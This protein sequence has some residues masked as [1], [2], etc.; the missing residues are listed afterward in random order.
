VDEPEQD[1]QVAGET[2]RRVRTAQ[3]I[4]QKQEEDAKQIK[5]AT[6]SSLSRRLAQSRQTKAEPAKQA[7]A[8]K[9]KLETPLQPASAKSNLSVAA[10]ASAQSPATNFRR[11]LAERAVGALPKASAPPLKPSA[12]VAQ[13]SGLRAQPKLSLALAVAAS[14][15]GL[16]LIGGGFYFIRNQRG[17]ATDS[18]EA[19]NLR[20]PADQS[21]QLVSEATNAA[22]QGQVDSAAEKLNSAIELTPNDST[23][24]QLLAD[25]LQNA[26]RTE[27]A[28]KTYD[29]LLK[30]SPS[31]LSARLKAAD[32]Y[33][34]K[35]NLAEARAHYQRIISLNQTS[36]EA[37]R[38]QAAIEEI[39]EASALNSAGANNALA[40]T[41]PR[42]VAGA[43]RLGPVLPPGAS[44]RGAVPLIVQNPFALQQG[45]SPFSWKPLRPVEAPDPQVL[46]AQYKQRGMSHYERREYGAAI[47]E[48]QSAVQL[49]PQDKDLYY[50]LG[51]AYKGSGQPLKAYENYR[52]CDAGVYRETAQSGARKT[53]KEARK[54]HERQQKA[55]LNSVGAGQPSTDKSN[56]AGKGVTNGFREQ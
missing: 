10:V 46:A 42:R 30:V 20:S 17:G 7:A 45:R 38:A 55:L 4:E 16:L 51:G 21:K 53:E 35:G 33:R 26:G 56:A 54:Q 22:Q 52:K 6:A 29:G 23:P 3:L 36:L 1:L 41:R 40:Q 43:K 11:R 14:V 47:R 9:P 48:L 18:N 19:R 2:L 28:L 50:F 39:E 24:R 13:V 44:E 15:L 25:T 5:Q 12:V 31:N 8:A 37:Q 49:T 34:S 32:L 27:E